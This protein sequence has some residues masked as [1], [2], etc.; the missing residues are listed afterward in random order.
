MQI[1]TYRRTNFNADRRFSCE[2]ES[3]P[4][5]YSS[6]RISSRYYVDWVSKTAAR[7]S[8]WAFTSH[9]VGFAPSLNMGAVINIL[10]EDEF[11]LTLGVI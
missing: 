8:L 11:F 4:Y 2:H 1:S 6:V 5:E 10:L 3:Y 7:M 9:K